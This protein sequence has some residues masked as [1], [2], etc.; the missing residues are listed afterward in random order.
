MRVSGDAGAVGENGG[1][2]RRR[3][4]VGDVICIIARSWSEINTSER[5]RSGQ[6]RLDAVLFGS[7][8]HGMHQPVVLCRART[9][10]E[11]RSSTRK[12][13]ECT[14]T[15]AEEHDAQL[16]AYLCVHPE[17]DCSTEDASS[18]SDDTLPS[19]IA[20]PD[21]TVRSFANAPACLHPP[22]LQVPGPGVLESVLL[23]R[24]PQLITVQLVCSLALVLTLPPRTAPARRRSRA[25]P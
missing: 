10:R 25:R 7:S 3:S 2:A 23:R 5:V 20:P 6:I 17:I 12:T 24:R 1:G 21:R 13:S 8:W 14:E 22:V 4:G 15:A 11:G 16:L 18:S 9:A 19:P